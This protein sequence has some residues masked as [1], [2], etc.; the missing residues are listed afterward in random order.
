DGREVLDHVL[1]H[2]CKKVLAGVV[3]DHVL[4]HAC[5]KVL[6]NVLQFQIVEEQP[7]TFRWRIVPASGTDG[8]GLVAALRAHAAAVL[9]PGNALTIELTERIEIPRGGK[10]SRVVRPA[11]ASDSGPQN[12]PAG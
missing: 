1:I 10:L 4:I 9:G 5:K 3:L 8:E 11:A 7:G 12:A 2:A 6:A